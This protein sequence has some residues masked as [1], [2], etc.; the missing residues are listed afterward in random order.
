MLA[1]SVARF[2]LARETP[3]TCA[4]AFSTRPEQEAQVMPPISSS[5]GCLAG[6]A[7]A[8]ALS[9]SLAPALSGVAR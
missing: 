4:S 2:T 1:R 3:G 6:A 9:M 5:I 7:G 8:G